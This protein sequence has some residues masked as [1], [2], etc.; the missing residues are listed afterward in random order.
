MNRLIKE[1]IKQK[2]LVKDGVITTSNAKEINRY[3]VENYAQKWYELRGQNAEDD[4]TGFYLVNRRG[5]YSGTSIL[6]SRAINIW[7]YIYNIGFAPYDA[8]KNVNSQT[9]QGQNLPLFVQLVIIL[10]KL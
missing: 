1:A 8:K 10:T 2:A 3:L 7:G 4:S 5:L 6:N 9:I